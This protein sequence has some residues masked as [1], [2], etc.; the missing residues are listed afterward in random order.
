MKI[1]DI[2]KK[3]E[4]YNEV[5]SMIGSDTIAI[6]VAVGFGFGYRFPDY[7]TFKVYVNGEF[8]PEMAKAILEYDGFSI[9]ETAVIECVSRFGDNLSETVEICI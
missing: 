4:T 7:R 6:N 3:V 5:A 1:K 2:F 8:I 9:G